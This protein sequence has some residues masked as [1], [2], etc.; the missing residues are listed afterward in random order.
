MMRSKFKIIIMTLLF[1]AA[2]VLCCMEFWRHEYQ[3][4]RTTLVQ[5]KTSL[6]QDINLNLPLGSD[7]GRVVEFLK[8]RRMT[9]TGLEQVS[10][11]RV[12]YQGVVGAIEAKSSE[13]TTPLYKCSIHLE[14]KFDQ[15]A[16]LL[17][18]TDTMPCTGFW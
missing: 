15:R 6:E 1:I 18:Y 16:K 17:G 14:L 10:R 12:G 2:L 4:S 9:H 11:D 7:E 3:R 5:A 8:A 13:I